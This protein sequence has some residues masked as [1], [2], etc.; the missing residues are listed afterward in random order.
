MSAVARVGGGGSL[1]SRQEAG[2]G[3]GPGSVG[4]GDEGFQAE[5]HFVSGV[6]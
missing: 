5:V 6:K 2:G 4:L 3:L 1:D